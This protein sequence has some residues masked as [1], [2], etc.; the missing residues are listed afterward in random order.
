MTIR[1]AI[2][3]PLHELYAAVNRA[4]EAA[5][6][7]ANAETVRASVRE[8]ERFLDHIARAAGAPRQAA[9]LPAPRPAISLYTAAGII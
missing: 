4:A 2:P 3:Q 9:P 6:H 7:D 8:T 1:P 5:M